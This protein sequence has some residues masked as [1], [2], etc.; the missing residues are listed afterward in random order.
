MAASR[1]IV[2]TGLHPP[3]FAENRKRVG[4]PQLGGSSLYHFLL[5]FTFARVPEGAFFFKL[6]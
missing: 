3:F 6:V 1:R 5:L 2:A 4:H